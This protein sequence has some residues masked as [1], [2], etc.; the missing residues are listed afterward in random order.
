VETGFPSG[1]FNIIN[2][3]VEVAGAAL[4]MHPDVNKIAFTGHL[5]T[6]KI[7]QKTAA[8]TLSGGYDHGGGFTM[9]GH[10]RENG[11]AAPELPTGMQ[12]KDTQVCQQSRSGNSA[13]QRIMPNQPGPGKPWAPRLRTAGKPSLPPSKPTHTG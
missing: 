8:N 2:G 11:E 7:T 9:S 12:R 5:N 4:G 10:G 13:W 6:A 1:I 3:I